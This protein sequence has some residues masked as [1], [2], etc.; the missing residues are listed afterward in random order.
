MPAYVARIYAHD[1]QTKS[2]KEIQP[3]L[4]ESMDS[5]LAKLS[6]QVDISINYSSTRKHQFRD[7]YKRGKTTQLLQRNATPSQK[8]CVKLQV[9]AT[10][11]MISLIAGLYQNLRNYK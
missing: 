7:K 6:A 3:L 9:E 10:R 8:Y 11:D 5:L 2:L 1:L 4:A